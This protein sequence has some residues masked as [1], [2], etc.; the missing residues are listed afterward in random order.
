MKP[1]GFGFEEVA[2]EDTAAVI[3]QRGDEVPLFLGGGSKE[4]MGGIMLDKFAD[5]VG[6]HLAVVSCFFAFAEIEVVLFSASDDGG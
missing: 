5:V 1:R 3:V 4:V 2:V 6:Q